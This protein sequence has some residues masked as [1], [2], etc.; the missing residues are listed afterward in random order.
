[1]KMVPIPASTRVVNTEQPEI[2][3]AR[4]GRMIDTCKIN[5]SVKLDEIVLFLITGAVTQG[6]S[7][8][9]QQAYNKDKHFTLLV[10]DDPQT[11]W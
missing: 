2:E 5:F 8:V 7:S 9:R 11:E 3:M 4:R 10:I 6:A 1:M